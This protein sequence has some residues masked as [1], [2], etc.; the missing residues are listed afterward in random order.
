MHICIHLDIYEKGRVER[1]MRL[2]G[3]FTNRHERSY[4]DVQILSIE[5][6]RRVAVGEILSRVGAA[7]G[8]LIRL[9][10]FVKQMVTNELSN[11]LKVFV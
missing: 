2:V 4:L 1:V 3:R 5:F 11:F 7:I 9:F 6:A 8:A 10:K